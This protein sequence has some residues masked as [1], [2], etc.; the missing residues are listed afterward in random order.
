MERGRFVGGADV[1][2]TWFFWRP[3]QLGPGHREVCKQFM[4]IKA[5]S[6]PST[7]SQLERSAG[8]ASWTMLV[9]RTAAQINTC[10]EEEPLCP[11]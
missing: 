5:V 9:W 3:C 6:V 10:L 11:G 8:P 7:P 1:H 4:Y 2:A